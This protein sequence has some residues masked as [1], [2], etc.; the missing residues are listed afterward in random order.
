MIDKNNDCGF[1]IFG[2]CDGINCTR[3]CSAKM[4]R[5]PVRKR[6]IL[7]EIIWMS[8]MLFVV[9]MASVALI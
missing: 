6:G 9:F 5:P 1:Y 4:Y 2:E 7:I 3:P 8:A